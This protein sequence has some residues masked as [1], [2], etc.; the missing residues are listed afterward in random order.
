MCL[1]ENLL[2]YIYDMGVK[3]FVHVS[4]TPIPAL[5]EPTKYIYDMG[6]KGYVHVSMTPPPHPPPP[7]VL[8]LQLT[9]VY[10]RYGREGLCS[11][12]YDP[13]PLN[14]NLLKYIYD[15]GVKGYVHASLTPSP[16]TTTC[17]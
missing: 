1:N 16:T 11:C 2:K 12:E 6:V 7:R 3:G 15:M 9:E 5:R 17:A 13:P 14:E 10:L 8:E 4:M